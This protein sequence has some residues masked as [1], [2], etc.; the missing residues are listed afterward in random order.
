MYIPS[1][2]LHI[3]VSSINNVAKGIN[4]RPNPQHVR[5]VCLL[6]VSYWIMGRAQTAANLASFL[7]SILNFFFSVPSLIDLYQISCP[8]SFR[9]SLDRLVTEIPVVAQS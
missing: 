1:Y 4:C 8:V 3:Q 6:L 2:Q 5:H 9:I 7:P